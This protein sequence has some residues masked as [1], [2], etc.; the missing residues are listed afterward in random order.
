MVPRQDMVAIDID[1]PV[2]SYLDDILQSMHS[3][4]PVY[5]EDIDNIIGILST[6]ALTI[7]ARKKSFENLDIRS[8]L[9][10]AYSFRKTGVQTPFQGNAAEK[11]KNWLY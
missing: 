7:E 9:T 6:K 2:D 5:Q 8:L 3:K 11:K 4:I 1:E 10:P